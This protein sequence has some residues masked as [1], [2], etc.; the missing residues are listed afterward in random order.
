MKIHVFRLT[1]GMDL[2]SSLISFV[3]KHNISAGI[4]L[5]CVGCVYESNIRLSDGVTTRYFKENLEILSLSGTLSKDGIHVHISM[6]DSKGHSYGG[7]LLEGC[8][9]NTTAEIAIGELNSMEF[10]RKYDK[11]TGYNELIINKI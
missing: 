6:A 4:I 9:V 1:K 11:H 8:L 5:T 3:K 10:S 7:H 2:K